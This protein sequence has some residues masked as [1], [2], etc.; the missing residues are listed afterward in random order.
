MEKI[1]GKWKVKMRGW[2]WFWFINYKMIYKGANGKVYGFNVLWGRFVWGK[3]EVIE[4][5]P[6]NYTF[7]YKHFWD[8]IYPSMNG[9]LY[10][11]GLNVARFKLIGV[12]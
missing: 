2:W 10:I 4:N 3:F 6:G 8:D 1:L 9:Y 7:K 11:K 12:S 5:D